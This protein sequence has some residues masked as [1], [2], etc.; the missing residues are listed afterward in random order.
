MLNLTPLALPLLLA[1]GAPAPAASDLMAAIPEEA[2]VALHVPNPR[3]IIAA[4]ETNDL[5]AFMLDPEW[6]SIA[7]LLMEEEGTEEAEMLGELKAFRDRAI[8]AMSD[9]SG[10]AVYVTT[11][12]ETGVEGAMGFV[13][14][15]GPKVAAMIEEMFVGESAATEQLA[16]GVVARVTAPAGGR[17]ALAFA[18]NGDLIVGVESSAGIDAARALVRQSLTGGSQRPGGPFGV[19]DLAKERG[20]CA[21]E[22]AVNLQP[23]L[24][25]ARAEGFSSPM[26]ERMFDM[27]FSQMTWAYGSMSL[28][29]GETSDLEFVVP[30]GA[31]SALARLFANFNAADLSSFRSIPAEAHTAQVVNVDLAGIFDWAM[32]LVKAED[33]MAYEQV[34]A[35]IGSVTE[36]SG[37]DLIEDVLGNLSGQMLGFSTVRQPAGSGAPTMMDMMMASSLGGDMTY[38]FEVEDSEVLL[39]AL[40]FMVDMS[41]MGEMLLS[42]TATGGG[43]SG[44]FETWSLDP[45]IGSLKLALG[46]GHMLI[47]TNPQVLDRYLATFGTELGES[48]ASSQK[49]AAILPTLSGAGISIQ[50]TPELLDSIS[51]LMD[52][53][54]AMF[55]EALDLDGFADAEEMNASLDGT[56]QLMSIAADRV[57]ELGRRYFEGTTS[58]DMVME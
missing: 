53:F 57:V 17:K 9:S 13:A 54:E 11:V 31:E 30:Y 50:K 44:E 12:P 46:A 19:P 18:T 55:S 26:E 58:A 10:L 51:T 52:G 5:V 45:E 41:G 42:G 20:D 7:A 1:N 34:M 16:A 23:I 36:M 22:V 29:T 21:M 47:S 43:E 6:E 28:G 8:E 38:A 27:M 2:V 39:E 14:Q 15:G 4:R 24:D 35:G 49:V 25:V 32:K 48:F 56:F 33:E 40:E 3:A 37:I